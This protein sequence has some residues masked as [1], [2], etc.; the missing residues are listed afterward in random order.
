MEAG[1]AQPRRQSSLSIDV[2][3]ALS[4]IAH[5][6]PDCINRMGGNA[7]LWISESF[8]TGVTEDGR[9][10]VQPLSHVPHLHEQLEH[11]STATA[12][13]C[14]CTSPPLLY[15]F[16]SV[17]LDPTFKETFMWM[18]AHVYARLYVCTWLYVC[19]WLYVCAW[20]YV[21]RCGK[22]RACALRSQKSTLGA[23]P[24]ELFLRQGLVLGLKL[25]VR[26]GCQ[27]WSSRDLPVSGSLALG[28]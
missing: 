26:L 14:A 25:P 18:C 1:K 22:H 2:I 6:V 20:L 5:L 15:C 8:A 21:R 7:P 17:S 12:T 19:I 13:S 27:P 3:H 16:L 28:L 11:S 9:Q 4:L 10:G 24:Q 23:I